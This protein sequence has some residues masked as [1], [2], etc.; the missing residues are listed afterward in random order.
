MIFRQLQSKA[1]SKSNSY[2]C[3]SIYLP[4][5]AKKFLRNKL[6]KGERMVYLKD[7]FVF[8]FVAFAS[9]KM[10]SYNFSK[11]VGKLASKAPFCLHNHLST[12]CLAGL[13]MHSFKAHRAHHALVSYSHIIFSS[14]YYAAVVMRSQD[15]EFFIFSCPE[16]LNRTHCPS[17]CPAPLTIRHFENT[18]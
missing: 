2:S 7:Q 10:C 18:S 1:T 6:E 8:F 3:L 17:L 15:E 5:R 13:H 11:A 14:L 12:V 9:S 16:Q 4:V